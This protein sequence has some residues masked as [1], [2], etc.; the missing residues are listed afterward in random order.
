MQSQNQKLDNDYSTLFGQY[1][2][3]ELENSDLKK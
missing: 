3:K 2:A 1:K